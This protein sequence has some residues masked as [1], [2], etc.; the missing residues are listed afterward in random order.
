MS[1]QS[2]LAAVKIFMVA[3]VILCVALVFFVL[4]AFDLW[5]YIVYAM[6]GSIVFAVFI[7]FE[8]AMATASP[9]EQAGILIIGIATTK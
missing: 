7:A 3:A 9:E 4:D 2:R 6:V 1:A 5:R 8:F